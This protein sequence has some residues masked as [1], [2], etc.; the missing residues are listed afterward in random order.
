MFAP[1]RYSNGLQDQKIEHQAVTKAKIK[2]ADRVNLKGIA[3]NK[4]HHSLNFIAG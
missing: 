3:T 1:Q 4:L 2:Q